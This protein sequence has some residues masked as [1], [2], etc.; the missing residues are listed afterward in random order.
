MTQ[1]Q[2]GRTEMAVKVEDCKN[3]SKISLKLKPLLQM[4]QKAVV[5]MWGKGA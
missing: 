3:S 4:L 2:K 5:R 1:F